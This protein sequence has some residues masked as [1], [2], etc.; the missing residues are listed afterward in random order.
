MLTSSCV[1]HRWPGTSRDVG[2]GTARKELILGSEFF[3]VEFSTAVGPIEVG[4]APSNSRVWCNKYMNKNGTVVTLA[5]SPES[6]LPGCDA[7]D[8]PLPRP[9]GLEECVVFVDLFMDGFGAFHRYTA[10]CMH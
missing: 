8:P 6:K 10:Q 7:G 1:P 4:D 5:E 2:A 3:M 9:N